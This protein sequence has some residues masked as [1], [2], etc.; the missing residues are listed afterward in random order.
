MSQWSAG[1]ASHHHAAAYAA[2]R[3]TCH[4]TA[5]GENCDTAIALTTASRIQPMISLIAAELAA[6]APSRER[7]W[8][9][10]T[11]DPPEDRDRRDG[12]SGRHEERVAERIHR[13][14]KRGAEIFPEEKAGADRRASA[15]LA[16]M[17]EVELE[18]DLGTWAG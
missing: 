11:N 10:S 3:A 7:S 18:P 15:P 16:Q 4:A 9:N 12:E 8:P 2:S 1:R 14:S 13:W 6:T 5:A 17:R